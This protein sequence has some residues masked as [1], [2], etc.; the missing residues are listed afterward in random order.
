MT[1][2][3]MLTLLQQAEPEPSPA[4]TSTFHIDFAVE[5]ANDD[6]STLANLPQHQAR[7]SQGRAR[8]PA[9]ESV[10]SPLQS[11]SWSKSAE[12][13][14]NLAAPQPSARRPVSHVRNM[15]REERRRQIE[16]D[17]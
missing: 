1:R 6:D 3:Q 17:L 12:E 7:Q 13:G 2:Q 4:L 8:D 10:S 16:G 9:A 15:S 11:E 14:L 5:E